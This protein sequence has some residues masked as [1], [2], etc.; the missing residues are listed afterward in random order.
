MPI[1]FDLVC[2]RYPGVVSI[3]GR[4]P[5]VGAQLR[6]TRAL[7][8]AATAWC[9]ASAAHLLGGG[10]L[11]SVSAVVI[12]I[13]V[14]AWPLT[15]SLRGRASRPRLIALLGAGQAAMHG[16]FVVIGAWT[17]PAVLDAPGMPVMRAHPGHAHLVPTTVP[18]GAL[19]TEGLPGGT[20]PAGAGSAAGHTMSMLPSPMMVLAHACAAV[21]LGCALAA[22][23]RALFSLL[24]LLA[25]LARPAVQVCG[26]VLRVLAALLTGDG[27]T[28]VETATAIGTWQDIKPRLPRHALVRAIP[29]RGPPRPLATSFSPGLAA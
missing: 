23:E 17:A 26:Q 28:D 19:P 2:D 15:F 18:A 13:A 16:V 1:R 4:A 20:V 8:V 5:I 29:R 10:K 9:T 22:G 3:S 12:L 11:P 24:G 25:E 21:L 14:T 6:W 27:P 7:A